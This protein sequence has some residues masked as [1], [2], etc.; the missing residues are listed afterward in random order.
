MATS[1]ISNTVKDPTGAVVAD[2]KIIIRLAPCG[3]FRVTEGTEV[4]QRYETV[5]DTNGLW[6]ITLERN[7]NIT[8]ANTYYEVEEQIPLSRGGS[9]R[10]IFQVGATNQSLSAAIVT[11]VPDLSLSSYLTQAAADARYQQLA[12][13]GGVSDIADSR[14][15]DAVAAGVSTAAARADHIHER[16]DVNGTAAARAALSGNDLFEGLRFRETDGSKKLYEY[17]SSAWLQRADNFIV[18]D[19]AARTAISNAYEGMLVYQLDTNT[20]YRYDGS[21]WWTVEIAAAST[22]NY[23]PTINQGASSNIAKT[24]S[25]SQYRICDGI[26]EW[27]FKLDMTASG[28]AGT[29]FTISTPVTMATITAGTTIGNGMVFDASVPTIDT[30]HYEWITTTTISLSVGE[31]TNAG[32]G[33]TPNLAL[34]SGDSI[35]GYVRVP[36]AAAA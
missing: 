14:P 8:P 21:A 34:A 2:A 17:R 13:L 7:S 23:T 27:W 20:V 12:A 4:A 5:T 29:A 1:T 3:G 30:G 32:W 19:A 31:G 25:H 9:K 15:N 11:V 18:A 16:E 24:V 35:R 22:T 28:T 36:V 6:S 10:W 33:N 26:L